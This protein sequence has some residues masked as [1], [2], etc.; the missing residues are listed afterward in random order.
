MTYLRLTP[1]RLRRLKI[2]GP[3]STTLL[4]LFFWCRP[5]PLKPRGAAP[6]LKMPRIAG[7][8]EA[9]NLKEEQRQINDERRM[10]QTLLYM[11]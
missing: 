5:N 10:P 6:Y 11:L 7:A 2:R 1:D 9:E 4:S 8:T 3:G